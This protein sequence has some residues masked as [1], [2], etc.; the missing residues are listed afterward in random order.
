MFYPIRLRTGPT[1]YKLANGPNPLNSAKGQSP[2]HQIKSLVI[3]TG[4]ILYIGKLNDRVHEILAAGAG[5]TGQQWKTSGVDS[6]DGFVQSLFNTLIAAS[7]DPIQYDCLPLAKCN[8][9]TFLTGSIPGVTW[10]ISS[11]F[12]TGG[13]IP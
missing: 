9:P 1:P 2:Q 6:F 11:L 3:R 13:S 10:G 12:R 7:L 4:S 5:T 8:S